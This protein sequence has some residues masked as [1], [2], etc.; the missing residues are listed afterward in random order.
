MAD[1]HSLLRRVAVPAALAVASLAVALVV[2]EVLVRR[3]NPYGIS[4]YKDT[5]RYLNEAI[6][7][8]PDADRPDGRL[9][10]NR[11]NAALEFPDFSFRTNALGLRRG[12]ADGDVQLARDP[13]RARVLF[14]GDSVTLGWG[15]DDEETWIRRLE[16]EAR[17]V[18]GR[19]L[20]CLNAGHLQY[21]TVQ[22][23]DW[24]RTFGVALQ[25]EAVVLTFVVNDL[26]DAYAQ[27]QEYKRL[28][29][30]PPSATQRT[31]ARV[32]AWFRGLH[33]LY[34]FLASRDDAQ[35]TSELELARVEDAPGYAEGWARASA[36]LDGMRATCAELG[37]PFVVLDHTT[38]R[39]P[40]V[41]RWCEANGVPCYD[42]TFTAEEWARDIR[43]S[44]ADSHANALGNELLAEKARRA[45]TA[46]GVLAEAGG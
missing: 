10:H 18:D 25:P 27:L 2:A 9:F 26:D 35:T 28:L 15:V 30:T 29:A 33:G 46:A 36:A 32:L 23:L 31:R 22:E 6:E 16:R 41:A 44:V 11:P 14:L 40:D 8:P 39:I 34:H 42:L 7:I 38:P 12:A 20:E 45:L 5:N 17:F 3:L 4:Y 19:P 24:L 37:V 43:N 1:Q 13:A 21:N